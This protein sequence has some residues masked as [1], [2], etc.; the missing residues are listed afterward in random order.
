MAVAGLSLQTGEE[1]IE[2]DLGLVAARVGPEDPAGGRER[3]VEANLAAG[4]SASFVRDL[5]LEANRRWI[6]ASQLLDPRRGRS[7]KLLAYLDA[8]T[9]QNEVH[10]T[11]SGAGPPADGLTFAQDGDSRPTDLVFGPT[12]AC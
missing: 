9:P 8:S 2:R 10:R 4:A 11:S 6:G 3:A 1:E 5:D 7:P 12:L